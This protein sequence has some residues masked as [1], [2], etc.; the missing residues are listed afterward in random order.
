MYLQ[1]IMSNYL[2]EE[3][4]FEV[5][6]NF[7]PLNVNKSEWVY[8]EKR[9]VKTYEF[10][11]IKFLEQFVL[12]IVKYNREANACIEARFKDNKVGII[13][14]SLAFKLSEIEVEATKEIDK[15]KKDVMYYYAR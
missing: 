1:N 5:E 10:E 13:I 11:D 7:K 8:E 12:E 3:K 14:H 15:I 4:K 2:K 9:I 6:N